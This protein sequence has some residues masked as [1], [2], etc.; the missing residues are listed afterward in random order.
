[1]NG[2]SRFRLNLTH[3]PVRKLLAEY[4]ELHGIRPDVGLTDSQR[5]AFEVFAITE[6]RRRNIDVF[7]NANYIRSIVGANSRIV[8]AREKKL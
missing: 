4:K 8:R 7:D 1:M 3:E 5:G 6:G 2:P